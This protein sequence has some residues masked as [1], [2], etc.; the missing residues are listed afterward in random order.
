MVRW[1]GQQAL[2]L[3]H[4]HLVHYITVH[5]ADG[6][7]QDKQED[8]HNKKDK[9]KNQCIF[10]QPLSILSITREPQQARQQ[11]KRPHKKTSKEPKKETSKQICPIIQAS[12]RR[13]NPPLG[14]VAPV[15]SFS[16]VLLLQS[17][18]PHACCLPNIQ[19]TGGCKIKRGTLKPSWPAETHTR[20]AGHCPWLDASI[21]RGILKV[22]SLA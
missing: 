19:C 16:G 9:G 22:S 14:L 1:L 21:P 3:K 5:I 11:N 6:R 13:H 20:P 2:A 8:E 17:P 12:K 10:S 7:S 4:S 18:N 15:I